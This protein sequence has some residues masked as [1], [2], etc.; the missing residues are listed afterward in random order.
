[1]LLYTFFYVFYTNDDNEQKL[2]K[3]WW[4]HKFNHIFLDFL[5]RQPIYNK[6]VIDHQSDDK[7]AVKSLENRKKA[8]SGRANHR[9][10]T[11]W[12]EMQTQ[13]ETAWCLFNGRRFEKYFSTI[14]TVFFQSLL[15]SQMHSS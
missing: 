5:I 1:M 7:E 13:G 10:L 9:F 4:P 8:S 6:V 15:F 3:L 12:D 14:C 2:G 11:V